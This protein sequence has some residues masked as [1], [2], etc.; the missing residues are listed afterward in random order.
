M[1]HTLGVRKKKTAVACRPD[2]NKPPEA[3]RC[4]PGQASNVYAF[5]MLTYEVLL[6]KEPYLNEDQQALPHLL[7][8]GSLLVLWHDNNSLACLCQFRDQ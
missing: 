4:K 1:V 3:L 5:G 8:H 2:Y 6:R 7:L